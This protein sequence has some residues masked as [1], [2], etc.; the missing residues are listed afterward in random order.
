[1]KGNYRTLAGDSLKR[2]AIMGGSALTASA[3]LISPSA[4]PSG[5][6]STPWAGRTVLAAQASDQTLGSL[7]QLGPRLLAYLGT[8]DNV[9][10]LKSLDFSPLLGALGVTLPS[11][12]QLIRI[13]AT[14]PGTDI[15][16]PVALI[17]TGPPFGA[18]GMLGLNP[19]WVPALPDAIARAINATPYSSINTEITVPPTEV[20][21]PDYET[22]RADAYQTAYDATYSTVYQTVYDTTYA[23][24]YATT[25]STVYATA[26][27]T[28][29]RFSS[30]R[31]QC[32]TNAATSAATSSATSAA[33]STATSAAISA[34]RAAGDL[35][36]SLVP[37]EVTVG[38]TVPVSVDNLRIPTVIAFGLGSLATG[39]A[40]PAVV[41]DLP[42]QPGGTGEGAPGG[43][44]LTLLPMVLLRNPG[45]SNGGLAARFAPYFAMIGLNTV[46]PD[47]TVER[48]GNAVLVPLKTDATVQYDPLSDFPAWSNPI[49]LANSLAALLFPTYILRGTDVDLNDLSGGLDPVLNPVIN[50]A[51][52][53][54][55]SA[56][57][58]DGQTI[59]VIVPIL[60]YD[61]TVPLSLSRSD[62]IGL[63]AGMLPDGVTIPAEGYEAL[64]AYL[65]ARTSA[66]PLLEP[67][68]LPIDLLNMLTGGNYSNPFADAIEPALRILVN[69]GYTDVDQA[70]GYTRTLDQAG[71]NANS[72]GVPFGTM[73]TG[74]D[75]SR[76]PG[77]VLAALMLGIQNAFLG[78]GPPGVHDPATDPQKNP[79]MTLASLVGFQTSPSAGQQ[80][81]S[82]IG[83]PPAATTVPTLSGGPSLTVPAPGV[84]APTPSTALQEP[85]LKA[86]ADAVSATGRTTPRRT[87][88]ADGRDKVHSPVAD[89]RTGVKSV[90]D[91]ISSALKRDSRV[92]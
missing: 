17:T 75:W 15:P 72:G 11:I 77:D 88:F 67:L 70:N 9:A 22:M 63:A 79:L 12:D 45:R 24:T 92:Q 53:N 83:E 62:L 23:T 58:G 73:P 8:E 27:N 55:L 46:T 20:E 85:T 31:T 81:M 38:A 76:V 16:L 57:I 51:L 82:S 47:M 30:N 80:V 18:L 84:R 66:L 49:A 5:A 36:A 86:P 43:S 10:F 44:S 26:Y 19:L 1:M 64:N 3:M 56:A 91:S 37:R 61:V 33:T 42:N 35:A 87:G 71:L 21:N 50:A 34:A 13:P 6:A 78:G 68:R 89:V 59:D 54:A 69:L 28:T 7:D 39:M 48:D 74:V 29:C 40:Y 65:T 90:T 25:Y 41:A 2:A 32:A 14:V 60:G 4:V 52:G